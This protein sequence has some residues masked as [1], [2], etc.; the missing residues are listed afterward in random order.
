VNGD[1]R[2]YKPRTVVAGATNI[3][4]AKILVFGKVKNFYFAGIL[5]V[6]LQSDSHKNIFT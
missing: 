3:A 5:L 1:N 6:F 4:N 2:I